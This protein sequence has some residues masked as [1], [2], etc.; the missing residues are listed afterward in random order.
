MPDTFFRNE[1]IGAFHNILTPNLYIRVYPDGDVLYSIRISITCACPMQLELFPLD[2]QTCNLD[3]ASYGWTK[4]DL[5][6]VWR[7]D[8]P[9]QLAGNLSLPG[10]FQLGAY[11]SEYCDVK[12][13]TGDYS[14]L[15]VQLLF[16]RQL[17]FFLVTVYVPCSMTVSVSWMSFWLD[18]KY[19]LAQLGGNDAPD[20]AAYLLAQ[21]GG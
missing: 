12:T 3:I 7:D 6:Y 2:E 17:S 1:K 18:H 4:D 9:V 20:V 10:G 21:L 13:A 8:E 11:G 15:R 16:A 5:V 14:C 19:L